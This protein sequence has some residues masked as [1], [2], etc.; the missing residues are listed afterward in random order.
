MET[1]HKKKGPRAANE[2]ARKETTDGASLVAKLPQRKSFDLL[3][4]IG[5]P[6]FD[7]FLRCFPTISP[8]GTGIPKTQTK[9]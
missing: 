5:A 1:R 6:N 8:E 7:N 2:R 9:I 4:F 3:E